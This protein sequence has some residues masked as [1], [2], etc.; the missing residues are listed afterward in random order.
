MVN[1]YRSCG[2]LDTDGKLKSV[3]HTLAP[4]KEELAVWRACNN[5]STYNE[6]C[7]RLFGKMDIRELKGILA[8]LQEHKHISLGS[9]ENDI[10]AKLSAQSNANIKCYQTSK[11]DKTKL[12]IK[13]FFNN[14]FDCKKIYRN[15]FDIESLSK[16]ERCIAENMVYCTCNNIPFQA[17]GAAMVL[18]NTMNITDEMKSAVVDIIDNILNTGIGFGMG[19]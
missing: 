14:P 10:D 3:S 6:L 12:F 16:E 13:A 7:Y 15:T 11:K 5:T 17:N 18:Y 1:A 19:M 2:I 4:T 9:S 8:S